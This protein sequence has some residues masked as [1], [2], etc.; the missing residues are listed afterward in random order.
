MPGPALTIMR[1]IEQPVDQLVVG[2]RRGVGNE[3]IYFLERRGKTDQIEV[4]PPDERLLGRFRG[5]LQ[6]LDLKLL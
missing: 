2:V 1:G 3:L 6:S 4:R 5:G